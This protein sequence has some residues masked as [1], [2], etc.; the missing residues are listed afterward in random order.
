M[1]AEW[2][3]W[4]REFAGVSVGEGDSA[5]AGLGEG[6]TVAVG[7]GTGTAVASSTGAAVGLGSGAAAAVGL[8]WTTGAVVGGRGVGD[9]SPPQAVNA[10]TTTKIAETTAGAAN[11]LLRIF[12][13][14][15]E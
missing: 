10:M 14:N 13:S 5:G 1:P 12:P 7:V 6:G 3:R 2:S 9:F 11:F 4:G 15:V 8:G